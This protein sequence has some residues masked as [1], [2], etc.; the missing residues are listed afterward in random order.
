MEILKAKVTKDST[1]TATYRDETGTVT[2]EGKNLVTSDLL[3]SFSKL[4]SHMAFLCEQKEADGK[5]F[6]ED[7]PNNLDKVIEV[8]GYSIGGDGDNKGVTLTGKRFLKTNKVLNLNSPF[9]K[10]EDDNEPYQFAFE[11]EQAISTC[12]YEVNEYIFNKKWK[13]VQQELPFEEGKAEVEIHAEAVPESEIPIPGNADMENFQTAM[14]NPSVTINI[15]GK[16]IK[17][18]S[19]RRVS[20]KQ[21]AS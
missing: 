11:L 15:N 7:L 19:S 12:E 2:I 20:S 9:T 1:L 8:T 13:V 3:N 10:F 4:V 17:S 14:N 16:N 21:L 6:L 5:E 18:R